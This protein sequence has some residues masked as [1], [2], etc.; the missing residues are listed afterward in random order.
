MVLWIY[1]AGSVKLAVER[2]RDVLTYVI[3]LHY[4]GMLPFITICFIS[5]D[6][7]SKQPVV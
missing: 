1:H 6:L 4:H 3:Y 2:Y 7:V 5:D